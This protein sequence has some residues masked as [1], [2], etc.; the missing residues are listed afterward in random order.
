M[1][2]DSHNNT[3]KR[4]TFLK[5]LCIL[6]FVMCGLMITMEGSMAI[7]SLIADK[8]SFDQVDQKNQFDQIMYFAANSGVKSFRN[9]IVQIVALAG[10]LLMWKLKK[11]GFYIYVIAESFLYFEFLYSVFSLKMDAK[12]AIGAGVEMIW[13]LPFDLVFIIMYATQL[14]YMTWK[15]KTLVD[16][17]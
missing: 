12:S 6:S 11:V 4:P 9:L 17:H 7:F 5:V 1:T 13:P 8:R 10:V 3:T 2:K 14:K 16:I 15:S